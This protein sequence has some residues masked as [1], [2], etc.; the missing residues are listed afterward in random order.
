MRRG[1]C[2]LVVAGDDGWLFGRLDRHG[3]LDR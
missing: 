1:F 3:M 2:E